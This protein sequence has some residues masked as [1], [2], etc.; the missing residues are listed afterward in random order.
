[1][2]NRNPLCRWIAAFLS[3]TLLF[4]AAA[5]DAAAALWQERRAA[6]SAQ[7]ALLSALPAPEPLPLPAVSSAARRSSD[8]PLSEALSALTTA[9]PAS[10]GRLESPRVPANARSLILLIHD[11][12][13]NDEAQRSISTAIT[14]LCDRGVASLVG[15][16]G[17]PAEPLNLEPYREFPAADATRAA[18]DYFVRTGQMSGA[19][20][21]ALLSRRPLP[22]IVGLEQP[23]LYEKNVAAVRRA[24]RSRDAI[25]RRLNDERADLARR[26]THVFSPELLSLD[27]DVAAYHA[28]TVALG[29][30]LRRLVS[31]TGSP[32]TNV[33]R[34]L[35]ALSI[36]ERLSFPAVERERSALIDALGRR[37]N[38]ANAAALA[39]ATLAYRAGTMNHAAFYS[40]LEKIAGA[41]GLALSSYPALSA[42][43]RYVV[44]IDAIDADGLLREAASLERTAY[45]RIATND[46]ERRLIAESRRLSLTDRL[47]SFSLTSSDWTE[48]KSLRVPDAALEPFEDFYRQAEARDEALTTN[49]LSAIDRRHARV[50]VLVAGG[51]HAGG[52]RALLEKRGLACV[53]FVPRITK[54]D[55]SSGNVYLSAFT[56]EKT[57]IETLFAGEKLFLAQ[58]PVADELAELLPAAQ[59]AGRLR[60]VPGERDAL[61]R[62]YAA[63]RG[64]RG[65]LDSAQTADGG[66]IL[67]FLEKTAGGQRHL[68]DRFTFG[69][70][71]TLQSIQISLNRPTRVASI[72]A[73]LLFHAVDALRARSAIAG[74][75]AA[76]LAGAVLLP[77][78]P[79][80]EA[81]HRIA[82]RLLGIRVMGRNLLRAVSMA[83]SQRAT[84]RGQMVLLAGPAVHLLVGGILLAFTGLPAVPAG[85]V[86]ASFVLSLYGAAHLAFYAIEVFLSLAVAR[87]DAYDAFVSSARRRN[88]KTLSGALYFVTTG[89]AM[90]VLGG[91]T[92]YFMMA[93]VYVMV[94]AAL[95]VVVAAL[96]IWS[97]A[98][99]G[100]P[101]GTADPA[102]RDFIRASAGTLL[103]PGVLG[104]LAFLM[105]E[106]TV[107][108]RPLTAEELVELDELDLVSA[109]AAQ[110][111]IENWPGADGIVRMVADFRRQVDA[112]DRR[113][114][115]NN[116][117]GAPI[118]TSS[119]IDGNA[120]L[121]VNIPAWRELR[122][123]ARRLLRSGDRRS[124][125]GLLVLLRSLLVKEYFHYR[126]TRPQQLD[127]ALT[128]VYLRVRDRPEIQRDPA[129]QSAFRDLVRTNVAVWLHLEIDGEV[130][131]TTYALANGLDVPVLREMQA[132]TRGIARSYINQ[133]L[134]RYDVVDPMK[135]AE[136]DADSLLRLRRWVFENFFLSPV[137]GLLPEVF[138]QKSGLL[139]LLIRWEIERGTV[140]AEADGTLRLR[141]DAFDYLYEDRYANGDAGVEALQQFRQRGLLTLR[142][143]YVAGRIIFG[144]G[145]L[146][147]IGGPAIAGLSFNPA[148][149]LG[150]MVTVPL[151]I[152]ALAAASS[153]R[154]LSRRFA[155]FWESFSHM[156]QDFL[157]R[158]H[159][160]DL[161]EWLWLAQ[162]QQSIV[163]AYEAALLTVVESPGW[164]GRRGLSWPG[165]WAWWAGVQAHAR[166]NDLAWDRGLRPLTAGSSGGGIRRSPLQPVLD[167]L[168]SRFVPRLGDRT[169]AL[170]AQIWLEPQ[171]GER[172]ISVARTMA[173]IADAVDTAALTTR[174]HVALRALVEVGISLQNR[175]DTFQAIVTELGTIP[176]R[177]NRR[178]LIERL[179]EAVRSRGIKDARAFVI[180]VSHVV[181]TRPPPTGEDEPRPTAPPVNVAPLE[182]DAVEIS[183]SPYDREHEHYLIVLKY[184][185]IRDAH[186]SLNFI[187]DEAD[188]S[189]RIETL[190][191][192]RLSRLSPTDRQLTGNWSRLLLDEAKAEAARRG[193]TKVYLTPPIAQYRQ[194]TPYWTIFGDPF[195]FHPASYVA[196][197]HY[198]LLPLASGFQL[199]LRD[200]ILFST[201]FPAMTSRL[202]WEFDVPPAPPPATLPSTYAAGRII[203][204]AAALLLAGTP[205]VAGLTFDPLY[206]LGWYVTAPL[207]VLPLLA[208]SSN[209]WLSRKFAPVWESTRHLGATFVAQHRPRTTHEWFWLF[210]GQNFIADA[211][212]LA[213][214]N[215]VESTGWLARRGLRFAGLRAWWAGVKAHA[216][217]N[218][219][220]WD[221]GLRPLTVG[222][223]EPAQPELPAHSFL[224]A[225][226][227]QRAIM[228]N[229]AE[230]ATLPAVSTPRGTVH[231]RRTALSALSG[232]ASTFIRQ[233]LSRRV[234]ASMGEIDAADFIYGDDGRLIAV[235]P[236]P[237]P[238]MIAFESELA[239]EGG[240]A[241]ELLDRPLLRPLFL[242]DLY[243]LPPQPGAASVDEARAAWRRHEAEATRLAWLL[244]AYLNQGP[245][246]H[247]FERPV[248]NA[249]QR[250]WQ[251]L[252]EGERRPTETFA[253]IHITADAAGRRRLQAAL[254]DARA[255]DPTATRRE[256]APSF[257]DLT[258][259][260]APGEFKLIVPILP[261]V[262]QPGSRGDA[263]Y[264]E[265]LLRLGDVYRAA[266]GADLT[267]D[268]NRIFIN[269][270]GSGM[271]LITAYL[272]WMAATHQDRHSP[273]ARPPDIE[274]WDINPIARANAALTARLAG[275][276]LRFTPPD[277]AVRHDLYIQNR[278]MFALFLD[279]RGPARSLEEIHDN[280]DADEMLAD[281][282]FYRRKLARGGLGIFWDSEYYD[283][284][285]AAK[286]ATSR[287]SSYMPRDPSRPHVPIVATALQLGGVMLPRWA[288]R[289]QW[290][291]LPRPLTVHLV[292]E[293]DSLGEYVYDTWAVHS[294][295][296]RP[297]TLESTYIAARILLP[298]IGGLLVL[299]PT[300]AGLWGHPV[301]FLGLIGALPLAVTLVSIPFSRCAISEKFAPV[302][303]SFSHARAGF[304]L[305][306]NPATAEEF[307]WLE[308]GWKEIREAIGGRWG[309]RA[310]WA[311]VRAHARFNQLAWT[312]GLRPLTKGSSYRV[313][314]DDLRLDAED[315]QF[316]RDIIA[317]Q[318]NAWYALED[319][320]N[321]LGGASIR[322]AQ[323]RLTV[324]LEEILYQTNGLKLQSNLRDVIDL[325]RQVAKL[326]VDVVIDDLDIDHDTVAVLRAA[327]ASNG[328]S[329][330]LLSELRQLVRV[331]SDRK[332]WRL[333]IRLERTIKSAIGFHHPVGDLRQAT[334]RLTDIE[335]LH[336]AMDVSDLDLSLDEKSAL[337]IVRSLGPN[338][339]A[340]LERLR[341]YWGYPTLLQALWHVGPLDEKIRR[342]ASSQA[343]TPAMDTLLAQLTR[344]SGVLVEATLD[345]L[346]SQRWNFPDLKNWQ[347]AAVRAW[348]Q[349]VR[350]GRTVT[351]DSAA[352]WV[353]RFD[354]PQDRARDV[355]VMV[356]ATA[357]RLVGPHR[358]DHFLSLALAR[359]AFLTEPPT[360]KRTGP[361]IQRR[362][363]LKKQ[364]KR[365]RGN[366]PFNLYGFVLIVLAALT[367][368]T[369]FAEVETFLTTA[370]VSRQPASAERRVAE[371]LVQFAVA[372]ADGRAAGRP[373][374]ELQAP[375]L[376]FQTTTYGVRSAGLSS[377]SDIPSLDMGR[378]N[379]EI[380][381][382]LSHRGGHGALADPAVARTAVRLFWMMGLKPASAV[383]DGDL[384]FP[385]LTALERAAPGAPV[386]RNPV[387]YVLV[388]KA[389]VPAVDAL[390]TRLGRPVRPV[391]NDHGFTAGGQLDFAAVDAALAAQLQPE[392]LDKL[393]FVLEGADIE[394]LMAMLAHLPEGS[395]LRR[396]RY[397]ALETIL[398]L[399][400]PF[401]AANL[402]EMNAMAEAVAAEQA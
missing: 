146:L 145:A 357:L 336:P 44:L 209:R 365:G 26:K 225:L 185:K 300:V 208:A 107:Y 92:G 82:G 303:E 263:G 201:E 338:P 51:F 151:A 71:G 282:Q 325:L 158:H 19:V 3:A 173:I 318:F 198:A 203:F 45:D 59:I 230:L 265:S 380:A 42:Y 345:D 16:E 75:I 384:L 77:L 160:V 216:R 390:S 108:P 223:A 319:Y 22:P 177:E 217:F 312:L 200:P 242:A 398:N 224:S 73:D 324:L 52:I 377:P 347:M 311:G 370:A 386:D 171:F 301:F 54:A 49:L 257:D 327:A 28:G 10:A 298:L 25:E 206:L 95:G 192:D 351:L 393:R 181:A 163:Q 378:L 372:F 23:V 322:T 250:E 337:D 321:G 358:P 189:L 175:L 278:P 61:A 221:L 332:A 331:D 142:G 17:A 399:A 259:P 2:S 304:V 165:F 111:A 266:M 254:V 89:L 91:F 297:G 96:V 123:E 136:A 35:S 334:A 274:A 33:A 12:H 267:P 29:A 183:V 368:G 236:V 219:M 308:S 354:L 106:R 287:R 341:A 350:Q 39:G 129:L 76:V 320:R 168:R 126:D 262:Y 162:G 161:D 246:G 205:V 135:I 149:F 235:L 396:V 112:G 143:T 124:A 130:D 191:A 32:S 213:R 156:K 80:Q 103:L 90:A 369:A 182:R 57:P 64:G 40:T 99:F 256:G 93:P 43:L 244:D 36:E 69:P 328:T 85:G 264:H 24:A 117:L 355:L 340:T 258:M 72:T 116:R 346:A 227:L 186:F 222:A 294:N 55:P 241:G 60:L 65:R 179:P 128:S 147:F 53:G 178:R 310:W 314:I 131:Q 8:A 148:Y 190:Q 18:A 260:A 125:L 255:F 293:Q 11:V 110:L 66:L 86:N 296:A 14:S 38:A 392:E 290:E 139:R 87:G 68:S 81:G 394:T 154:W 275:I 174:D 138:P 102:R 400:V 285:V 402:I 37:L 226:G 339:T 291:S 98:L 188:R 58:P 132:T 31:L 141:P 373:L 381:A 84:V 94:A 218:D 353:G 356:R 375:V 88:A 193:L 144:V 397:L 374:N 101:D 169:D 299:V 376:D 220:A 100:H 251:G 104:T 391:I 122:L 243:F 115:L 237:T 389:D 207:A 307:E 387:L 271:D 269:G 194:W 195:E 335:K 166:F 361:E 97:V 114:I 167:A 295:E 231:V 159:P 6:L 137:G 306:H 253:F 172:R 212:Q 245:M 70:D 385:N 316:L 118:A 50:A 119:D 305:R 379:A 4:Q 196:Q 228:L 56:R 155:P 344:L 170:I 261:T 184:P 41:S 326:P 20:H 229:A 109:L 333:L 252:G 323:K 215:A 150:W 401:S 180:D 30:Y 371:S 74:R 204:G 176:G 21:G 349:D 280:V 395:A 105:V 362:R 279:R 1:M 270:I 211:V 153:N 202:V 367:P 79:L 286:T 78:V 313:D 383:P 140:A 283:D 281:F 47:V 152:L 238:G 27:R 5:A 352:P 63:R 133:L 234:S 127:L 317:F 62:Y 48:Y 13:R 15:L 121:M 348:A 233:Q 9:L 249:V 214:M 276:P 366:G 197:R 157:E 292:D 342:Q 363:D 302:W 232:E 273:E 289:T 359:L 272:G 247:R 210:S 288:N 134:R 199:R 120:A 34:F 360:R 239:A 164:L 330:E 248:P 343:I 46:A 7:H 315:I 329:E 187:V 268:K 382:V 277:D 67:D 83:D 364:M 309:L 284:P 240:V 113:R 388:S